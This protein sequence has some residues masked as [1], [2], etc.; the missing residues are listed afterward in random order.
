MVK[1][2]PKVTQRSTESAFWIEKVQKGGVKPT[3]EEVLLK[4]DTIEKKLDTL[5]K[6]EGIDY[7]EATKEQEDEGGWI[8]N[9]G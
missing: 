1:K 3:I 9:R 4:L 2:V 5:L 6:K 7:V 8:T